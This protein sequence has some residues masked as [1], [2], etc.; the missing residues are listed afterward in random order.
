M[1]VIKL[2]NDIEK[3]TLIIEIIRL[4]PFKK[5]IALGIRCRKEEFKYCQTTTN[6]TKFYSNYMNIL[7][8]YLVHITF[9]HSSV[10]S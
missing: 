9:H 10:S 8:I 1:I 5:G 2:Y 7:P 6:N 3:L 4:P